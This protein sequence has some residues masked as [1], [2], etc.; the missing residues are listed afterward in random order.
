[1]GTRKVTRA[2]ECLP[3][4]QHAENLLLVRITPERIEAS[5]RSMR[6]SEFV[7]LAWESVNLAGSYPYADLPKTNN[8]RARRAPPSRRA[9]AAFRL[10][11]KLQGWPQ[12]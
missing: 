7:S 6:Q 5:R 2:S 1:M 8:H 9:V 4:L 12:T 11:K 3:R 10:L